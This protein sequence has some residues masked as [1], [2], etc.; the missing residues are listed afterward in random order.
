[1]QEDRYSYVDM[2][3]L[4]RMGADILHAGDDG[5]IIRA[6]DGLVSAA[7]LGS[8]S[9]IEERLDAA[10]PLICVHDRELRDHLVEK[11][12][13]T[14]RE[15]C[16]S[17]SWRGSSI[18]STGHDIHPLTEDYLGT[19]TAVYAIDSEDSIRQLLR[20]GWIYGLFMEG[21][22]AG[23]AGFHSEGSMG[24]LHIFEGYRRHGYGQIMEE[25]VI[26][27]ALSEGR[28]P[29]CH[30]FFSN[31]A[32]IRLQERIGMERGAK[33]IWWVWRDGG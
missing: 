9:S 33:P 17:F 27:M 4:L 32:S 25:H 28:I 20:K 29:Y 2:I 18:G 13:Y 3:S 23:F 19:I 6:R 21:T 8:R 26:S 10:W 14:N 22:L 15:G 7:V 1:M 12:G 30:V 31:A 24:L 16:W 11:H 5:I